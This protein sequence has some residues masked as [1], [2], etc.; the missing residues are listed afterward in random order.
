METAP[1]RPMSDAL[2]DKAA[3]L[4]RLKTA[5][6]EIESGQP[7][8]DLEGGHGIQSRTFEFA[9][10]TPTLEI[11][12]S[13]PYD[14]V[15]D[16][17]ETRQTDDDAI[18]AA[19]RLAI[20]LIEADAAGTLLAEGETALRASFDRLSGAA[21]R[22]TGPDGAVVDAADDWAPLAARLETA[23]HPAGGDLLSIIW[24]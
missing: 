6:R 15:L 16:D 24:P 4:D 11:A 13:M 1:L 9:W 5:I 23:F 19:C 8:S 7:L 18:G 22:T 21:Y 20:L 12:F 14:R 2:P 3:A 10:K 17:D